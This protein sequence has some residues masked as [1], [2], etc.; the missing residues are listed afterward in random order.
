M[1]FVLFVLFV[2]FGFKFR[3][4]TLD[5]RTKS[6]GWQGTVHLAYACKDGAEREDLLWPGNAYA[7]LN[8]TVNNVTLI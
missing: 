2:S 7:E 3:T 8:L 1:C 4:G 6:C 5:F